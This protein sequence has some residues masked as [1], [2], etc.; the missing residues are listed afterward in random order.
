MDLEE[1]LVAQALATSS[2]TGVSVLSYSS[3]EPRAARLTRA[4]VVGVKHG[5][6]GADHKDVGVLGEHHLGGVG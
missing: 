1:T 4:V 2:V 3:L 6:E 5:E